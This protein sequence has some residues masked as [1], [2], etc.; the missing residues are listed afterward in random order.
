M[1]K[2]F[3]WGGYY[4]DKPCSNFEL[5]VVNTIAL[6]GTVFHASRRLSLEMLCYVWHLRIKDNYVWAQPRFHLNTFFKVDLLLN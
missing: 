6:T 5:N 2:Y 1:I 4:K 3:I